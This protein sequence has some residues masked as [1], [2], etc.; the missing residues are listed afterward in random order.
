MTFVETPERQLNSA[1]KTFIMSGGFGAERFTTAVW[2]LVT[3]PN[4]PMKDLLITDLHGRP[5]IN[6]IRHLQ[7]NGLG[8]VIC[9]GDFDNPQ[10]IEYL[11]DLDIETSIVLGNHDYHHARGEVLGGMP[12]GMGAFSS[13]LMWMKCARAREFVLSN[14]SDLSAIDGQHGIRVV[15]Q[16][17]DRNAV[18]VHALLVAHDTDTPQL[19]CFLWSRL[20]PNTNAKLEQNFLAM[21]DQDYW[22]MFRGHD[23]MNAVWSLTVNGETAD[24]ARELSGRGELILDLNR[25]YI[26]SIGSFL[27]GHYAVFDHETLR[28]EF[29]TTTR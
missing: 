22:I 1:H 28:L 14:S 3:P 18:Y 27:H 12:K 17:H 21:L 25:R 2:E 23:D 16:I 10:L 8:R 13:F 15:R 24:I 11:L 29:K 5:P 6:L 20:F 26:V 7:E 9:L 4:Q 19:S